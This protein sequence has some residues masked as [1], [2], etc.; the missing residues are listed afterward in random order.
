VPATYNLR[1]KVWLYPGAAAWHF[2][3]LS[4]GPAREI[5][6]FFGGDRAWGSVPVEV[7]VGST[8]WKTS[9]FPDKK[10]ASYVLPLKAAV[11]K[12]E[13]IKV[14]ATISLSLKVMA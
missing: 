6:H 7:T 4:K 1:A 11:R 10:S 13:A 9:V 2:V 3:T 14:G 12:A 8:T 5:Q